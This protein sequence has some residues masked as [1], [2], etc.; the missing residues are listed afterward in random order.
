MDKFTDQ[1]TARKS[2]RGDRSSEVSERGREGGPTHA[3]KLSSSSSDG[4]GVSMTSSSVTTCPNS[5]TRDS[6]E[7]VH[8]LNR[9]DLCIAGN[10]SV[11][12]EERFI[13][14]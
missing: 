3:P 13:K 11:F 1:R 6:T 8:L 7:R 9:K 5:A 10:L 2:A 4:G 12:S 14:F